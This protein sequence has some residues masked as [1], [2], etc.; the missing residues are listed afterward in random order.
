M[1]P[2]SSRRL[3]SLASLAAL[4]AGSLVTTDAE[5]VRCTGDLPVL[6]VLQDRSNSMWADPSPTTCGTSCTSKWAIAQSVV[7]DVVSQFTGN[8]RFGMMVFPGDRVSA[9]C[10][11]GTPSS[12]SGSCP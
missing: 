7:P 10:T 12:R 9:S 5:A 8:F 11:T 1:S 2:F 3:A 6:L 4:A